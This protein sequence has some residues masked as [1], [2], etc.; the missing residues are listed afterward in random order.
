RDRGALSRV[1]DDGLVENTFRI[2]VI[3]STEQER[4]FD[5]TVDGL[6]G[7]YIESGADATVGSL[8]RRLVVVRVRAAADSGSSGSNPIHFTVAARDAPDVVRREKSVFF[9][10]Q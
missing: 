9:L 3:N 2:M 7:A 1:V 10:P 4:D 6:P 5:L 8:E